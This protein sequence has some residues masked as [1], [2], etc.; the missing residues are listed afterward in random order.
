M[1]AERRVGMKS[2]EAGK[3]LKGLVGAQGTRTLDPL[4]KSCVFYSSFSFRSLPA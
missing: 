4:I 2:T 1:T 3:C